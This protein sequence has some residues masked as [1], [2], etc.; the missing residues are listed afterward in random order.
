MALGA[1]L[2]SLH[3]ASKANDITQQ[4]TLYVVSY[5]HLD[6]EWCWTYKHSILDYIPTTF[7]E[8]FDLIDKNPHYIFNWT[9][10][11]RYKILKEYYP[12]L[13]GKLKGYVAR[14][15]WNPT[16]SAWDECDLMAPSHESIIRQILYGNEFFKQEFGKTSNQFMLPDA[17][18]FPASL[19]TILTHCGLIGFST[20]K[21]NYGAGCAVGIP[22][23]FGRWIGPDGTSVFAAF[24]PSDYRT[25]VKEDLSNSQEWLKRLN[26]NGTGSGVFADYMYHGNGDTGGS[27]GQP[28]AGWLEK[29]VTGDGPT[30][31]LS[32]GADDLFT[33][34]AKLKKVHLPE[35]KGDLLLIEH[36]AGS[37]TSSEYTKKFNREGELLAFQAEGSAVAAEMIGGVPYPRTRLTDAWQRLLNG[38]M[39]DILP[40]T[41]IP[42]AYDLAWNDQGVAINQFK[43]VLN[44]SQYII[45]S[46]LNTVT[47][48]IPVVVSNSLAVERD[49]VA[50]V[51]LPH[52]STGWVATGPDG[53]I[54]PV[55]ILNSSPTEDKVIFTAKVPSVGYAVYD[56]QKRTALAQL[57]FSQNSLENHRYLVKLNAAGDVN[58]IFDKML[59]REL[60]SGP[61][62]TVFQAEKPPRHPA[63]NM[64]WEDRQKPPY[65]VLSGTPKVTILE[66][67]PVRVALKV[68]REAEG[69]KFSQIIRLSSGE[70]GNRVEFVD[71]IDWRSTGCSLKAE[72]P[73]TANN[74]N[75]TYNWG[76][77]TVERGNNDPKKFEVPSHSWFDLSDID[78]KFGVRVLT[79]MKLGSDKPADNLVR[80]TLLYTPT[81]GNS[82]QYQ[83]S[84]DWGKHSISY[85]LEG[86][87]GNW[88]STLASG[89]AEQLEQPLQAW[90]AERHPGSIGKEFSLLKIS[91]PSI[92]LSAI[93]RSES[94]GEVIVR[95]I[96]S[97][98]EPA[99]AVKLTFA[100]PV[101]SI[102]EVNGQEESI[103]T[104]QPIDEFRP[105]QIRAF[106]VKFAPTNSVELSQP[107]KFGRSLALQTLGFPT[108]LVPQTIQ[109]GL[110][111]FSLSGNMARCEG[112][113]ISI[114]KSRKLSILAAASGDV[115]ATFKV[116]HLSQKLAIQSAYGMI[117]KADSR[118]WE[119]TVPDASSNWPNKVAG[120]SPGYMKPAPIAWYSDHIRVDGVNKPYE[121]GYLFRYELQVPEGATSLTLPKDKRIV[122]A[123]ISAQ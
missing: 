91:N 120:I 92:K 113:T 13:F 19:P 49:D 71:N 20:K 46:K 43:D 42:Q 55:Q 80:L 95:L 29:S 83:A 100:K 5:S 109:S 48:G 72:F 11:T 10:A 107:V 119:G 77:G 58:S 41:S 93:K 67:G 98:S 99:K 18:G 56:L 37:I 81:T 45:S 40:G 24:N 22:F 85:G 84:Q 34:A 12:D 122:I 112:Q 66:K 54:R 35:Y 39:H 47:K 6:T 87:T 76:V 105:N 51:T 21:L 14:G 27:P 38:Q 30:R 108:E 90:V 110:Y 28:S 88:K 78:G 74:P 31:I 33:D 7:K 82:Y 26:G 118:I 103:R 1:V 65:A 36:S 9:G 64:V 57:K 79:G 53:K 52:S 94:T 23:N 44:T 15:R 106:A 111:T 69:S 8:N 62:R 61:K 25:R 101:Q 75:A 2:L 32:A 123:A 97:K 59:N 86:H 50:Q 17:F 70:A 63:W 89:Q 115:L 3:S 117:N 60:L 96:E 68:D 121:F 104:N 73:L 102:R 16:G 116:G 4:P 114:P